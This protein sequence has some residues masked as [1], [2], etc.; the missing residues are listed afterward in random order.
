M[1]NFMAVCWLTFDIDGNAGFQIEV[2]ENKNQ[3]C[4]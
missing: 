3:F 4:S 1:S 2:S